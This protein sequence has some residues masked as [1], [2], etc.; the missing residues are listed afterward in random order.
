MISLDAIGLFIAAALKFAVAVPAAVAMGF[1]YWQ[2]VGITISGG[3]VGLLV[4][5]FSSA[6]LMEIARKRRIKKE[7]L[8]LAAGKEVNHQYFNRFNKFIIKVKHK[9]GIFGIAF[10]TPT[11]LGIPLGAIIAAKFFKHK[12]Y[13]LPVLILSVVLWSV[14]FTALSYFIKREVF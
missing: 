10:I 2:S 4:F 9:V 13:T 3:I 14:A 6:G 12:R 7:S 11:I 1:N 5:Y 8:K